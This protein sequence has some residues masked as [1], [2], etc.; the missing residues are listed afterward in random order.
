MVRVVR[1]S[2]WA[3][4]RASSRAISRLTDPQEAPLPRG[5]WVPPENLHLTL[6]FLGELPPAREGEVRAEFERLAAAGM[7]EA[8]PAAEESTDD[9]AEEPVEKTA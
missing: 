1:R 6:V 8:A 7:A 3:S 2:S 9:K 5:R 4:R